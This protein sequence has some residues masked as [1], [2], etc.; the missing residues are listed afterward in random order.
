M[1]QSL[2]LI[3]QPVFI[4]E[5]FAILRIALGAPDVRRHMTGPNASEPLSLE[6][7]TKI[8][9]KLNLIAKYSHILIN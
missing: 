6:V 2:C 7:E 5:E 1:V 4:T 9:N 8:L 3:G